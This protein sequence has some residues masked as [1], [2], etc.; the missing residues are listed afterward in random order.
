MKAVTGR[1][2]PS[3]G[4]NHGLLANLLG[5]FGLGVAFFRFSCLLPQSQVLDFFLKIQ[6]FQENFEFKAP[7]WLRMT[8]TEYVSLQGKAQLRVNGKLS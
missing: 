4:L 3:M 5:H 6:R 2:S 8:Q 7:S 1:T